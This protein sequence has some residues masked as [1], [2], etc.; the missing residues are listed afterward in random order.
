MLPETLHYQSLP[1]CSLA[2]VV[3]GLAAPMDPEKFALVVELMHGPK[4]VSCSDGEKKSRSEVASWE[5]GSFGCYG[6]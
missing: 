1:E 4:S 3:V 6:K 2:W 5:F